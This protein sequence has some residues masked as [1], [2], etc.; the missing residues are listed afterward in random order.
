MA[1]FVLENDI[2][3]Y[4]YKKQIPMF[5]LEIQLLYLDL[6]FKVSV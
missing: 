5:W 6:S 4:V 2:D 1:L 3:K